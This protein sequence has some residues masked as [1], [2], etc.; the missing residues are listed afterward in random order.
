M[1][2]PT[3][4]QAIQTVP[5]P[6]PQLPDITQIPLDPNNPLVWLLILVNL[7]RAIAPFIRDRQKRK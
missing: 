7:L 2:N 6:M 5:A 3:Q 4:T 1:L